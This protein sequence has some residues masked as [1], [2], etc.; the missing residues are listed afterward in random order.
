[1]PVPAVTGFPAISGVV[2][3]GVPAISDI[4]L[5]SGVAVA[6]DIP[7]VVGVSFCC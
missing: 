3:A 5:V 4:L 6:A 7:V 1:L 2:V